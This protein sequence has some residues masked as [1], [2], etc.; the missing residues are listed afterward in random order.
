MRGPPSSENRFYQNFNELGN[1]FYNQ[2]GQYQRKYSANSHNQIPMALK[3]RGSGAPSPSMMMQGNNL[4]NHPINLLKD[5]MQPPIASN[6]T[7]P[8]V[9]P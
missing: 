3:S 4:S 8:M 9:S 2:N 5:G 7:D 1:S 6:Q